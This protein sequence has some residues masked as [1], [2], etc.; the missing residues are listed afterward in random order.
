MHGTAEP[1]L[2]LAVARQESLF[3]PA[4]RSPAG[5]LGLMQLMPAHRR[6]RCHA[7]WASRY[8]RSRLIHDPDFNVR[9]GAF[10]LGQQLARF[11]N[12]PVLAL[13]AYNAGPRRVTEWLAL[14]GDPRGNDPYRLI[15]WI[16][17]IPFAET[18][19]YVQRVL[20][21]RGMY[22]IALGQPACRQCGRPTRNP[23]ACPGPSPPPDR[24]PPQGAN[25]SRGLGAAGAQARSSRA[26]AQSMRL[27][28]P[29]RCEGT[30]PWLRVCN[31]SHSSELAA[32]VIGS[33]HA[34]LQLPLRTSMP[35]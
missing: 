5:A 8:T 28:R 35:C 20:E 7:T 34:L 13:A 19:N 18:R 29:A 30:T 11:D 33:P 17:L 6:R 4:A 27:D 32:G 2:L 23:S 15:D 24:T 26:G 1:A 9:L 21:G 25:M 14:N 3:D 16:E 10:Y 12:E 22:R 31:G